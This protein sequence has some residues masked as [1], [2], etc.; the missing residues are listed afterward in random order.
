MERNMSQANW[1][2][3]KVLVVEDCELT[4][5]LI[6]ELVSE[7]LPDVE[8]VMTSTRQW[9][10]DLLSKHN[11]FNIVFLDW[12]LPDGTSQ[13]LVSRVRNTQM[14]VIEIVWISGDKDFR[15]DTQIAK[16]GATLEC[17]KFAVPSFIEWI[18]SRAFVHQLAMN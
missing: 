9:A 5:D 12:N 2:G 1:S 16:E 6:Q 17:E 10:L 11:D 8:L 7:D 15:V 14:D 3:L 18:K 13:W 4:T